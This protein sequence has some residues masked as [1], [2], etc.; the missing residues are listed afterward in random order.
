MAGLQQEV[1]LL[2]AGMEGFVGRHPADVEGQMEQ[3]AQK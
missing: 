3:D 2:A 1:L